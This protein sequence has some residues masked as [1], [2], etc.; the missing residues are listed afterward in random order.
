MSTKSAKKVG[1]GGRSDSRPVPAP[2]ATML[3]RLLLLPHAAAAVT[4]GL[5]PIVALEKQLL[6]VLGNLA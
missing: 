5:Y 2:D 3:L 6:K 1:E 4:L